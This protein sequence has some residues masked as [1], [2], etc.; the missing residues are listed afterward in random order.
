M[1]SL[2]KHGQG[3]SCLSPSF[4]GAQDEAWCKDKPSTDVSQHDLGLRP[5]WLLFPRMGGRT[6]HEHADE[7][8]CRHG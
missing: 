8:G 5:H 6:H 2:S 1:L 7:N 3:E 4:D